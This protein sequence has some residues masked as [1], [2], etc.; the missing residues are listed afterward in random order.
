DADLAAAV[1]QALTT[2]PSMT[3]IAARF[4]ISEER[5]H[6]TQALDRFEARRR[7]ARVALWRVMLAEGCSIGE[8]ARIFGLSRQLVSRQLRA[9]ANGN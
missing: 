9:G 4:P 8:I 5:T 1:M 7:H 3:E 6:L 2:A